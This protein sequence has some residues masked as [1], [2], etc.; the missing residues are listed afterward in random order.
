MLKLLF[1]VSPR[2]PQPFSTTRLPQ[3][4]AK[5]WSAKAANQAD[6]RSDFNQ[7]ERTLTGVCPSTSYFFPFFEVFLALRFAF[8]FAGFVERYALARGHGNHTREVTSVQQTC[9]VIS[10]K[11]N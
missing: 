4:H 11:D 6:E 9:R 2:T 10:K 3:C 1:M 8:F 7:N 5:A